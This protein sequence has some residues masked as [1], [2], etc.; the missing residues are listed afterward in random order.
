MQSTVGN[1]LSDRL[2]NSHGQSSG[3]AV[4]KKRLT[5]LKSV[6]E[7]SVVPPG[8]NHIVRPPGAESAG[9]LSVVP[10]GL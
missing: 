6:G 3:L 9:L 10:P 5:G 4:W 2:T 8:L 7:N 1:E